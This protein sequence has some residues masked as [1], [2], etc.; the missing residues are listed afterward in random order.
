[1]SIT[2]PNCGDVNP[3]GTR[4]CVECGE[5]LAW[6]KHGGEPEDNRLPQPEEP[7]PPEQHAEL[8]AA[9]SERSISVMPGAQAV[10]TTV[11][12]RNRGTRVERVGVVVEGDAAAFATVEPE[13]LV[14]PPGATDTC[15]IVFDPP[16]SP[17]VLAG[18]T[19]FTVVARSQVNR[20]V[21]AIAEGVCTVGGF[22]DLA[23]ELTPEVSRGRWTTR[24]AVT[25]NSRGNLARRTRLS[26]AAE[27]AL[28]LSLRETELLLDPGRTVVPLRVSAHP[29]LTGKPREIPFS[30][31]ASIDDGETSFRVKGTR[32]A[33]PLLPPWALK[34]LVAVMALAL[35]VIAVI[36]VVNARRQEPTPVAPAREPYAAGRGTLS[37]GYASVAVPGL[38]SETKIFLT[39]DLSGVAGTDALLGQPRTRER[40]PAASLGVTGRGGGSF[41]VQPIDGGG[42]EGMDFGYL[43]VKESSGTVGGLPYEAGSGTIPQG[44]NRVDVPAATVRSGSVI[45][46]TVELAEPS[47][48]SITGLKVDAKN[49]GAFTVAT[50][51]LAPAPMDLGF[52]WLVV[53]S[54]NPSLA[55][56]D[57]TDAVT[58]NGEPVRIRSPLANGS[59]VILLTTDAARR[60]LAGVAMSGV[61]VGG[62]GDGEFTVEWFADRI[63]TL[64]TDF[65][66]LIVPRR[67]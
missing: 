45:L 6:E 19:D 44:E 40:R 64:P 4:F 41:S 49:D 24:H 9:L 67:E 1:M 38:T 12:V 3:D 23:V 22:D 29:S 32:V 2:C 33:L 50:L 10:T 13:E 53:D 60:G 16:R 52:N 18:A 25:L 42:V 39:S 26:A 15:T 31:V 7:R 63:T 17:S 14:I 21:Y 61:S 54:G 58:E 55:G 51:D 66:Y 57:T 46:L 59:G 35:A 47:G 62:Q 5:Y 34:T 36:V 48:Y 11:T 56:V 8:V 20:G 43:A 37:G 30:V 27:D 65:D 28:R